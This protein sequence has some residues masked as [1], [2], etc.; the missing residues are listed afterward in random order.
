MQNTNLGWRVDL[1]CG[2]LR[3]D[4]GAEVFRVTGI[5][6]QFITLVGP[7]SNQDLDK[8]LLH[9]VTKICRWLEE[10]F[11]GKTVMWGVQC[12]GLGQ[13]G[14]VLGE[15]LLWM[16]NIAARTLWL[17]PFLSKTEIAKE[18]EVRQDLSIEHCTGFNI[19]FDHDND[20]PMH[21]T[22]YTLSW[23]DQFSRRRWEES[24]EFTGPDVVANAA[25]VARM[26]L[27]TV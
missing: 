23:A 4:C 5:S 9:R 22:P 7:Y 10:L 25:L 13:C 2:H 6:D 21:Q 8:D 20:N 26:K 14:V 3:S 27:A 16:P 11:E 1:K 19:S 15:Q 17:S 12:Q 18:W 24:I